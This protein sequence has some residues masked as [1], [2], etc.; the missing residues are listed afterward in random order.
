MA[1]KA[2][3]KWLGK[4]NEYEAGEIGKDLVFSAGEGVLSV[5][6]AAGAAKVVRLAAPTVEGAVTAGAGAVRGAAVGGAGAIRGAL[7][8]AG[9]SSRAFFQAL[10]RDGA[11][12]LV[13]ESGG[14]LTAAARAG[15]VTRGAVIAARPIIVPA[16][17]AAGG[18]VLGTKLTSSRSGSQTGADNEQTLAS[19]TPPKDESSEEAH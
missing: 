13:P 10:A 7:A 4:G 9:N 1:G 16:V 3:I 12:A 2:L 11:T 18:A 19:L 8:T 6:P 14:V 5:L 17:S 15:L